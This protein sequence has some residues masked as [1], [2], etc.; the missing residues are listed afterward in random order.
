M[1][2]STY[3]DGLN[4]PE[5]ASVVR[6][7]DIE[8]AFIE[9]LRSLKYEYRP[10]ITDRASLERNFREKFEALNRVTLTDA[11]F[12]RLLDEI[13]TSDVFTASK[14]LRSIIDYKN[15]PG[16]GYAKTLLCFSSSSSA[17]ATAPTTSRTTTPATLPSTLTSASCPSTNSPP[18]TTARSPISTSSRRAS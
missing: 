14:T 12:A 10:D 11:E 9:K 13:V 15:D 4:A 16:N 1:P 3:P 18:R 5:R 17:T 7:G 8:D 6:E 2:S